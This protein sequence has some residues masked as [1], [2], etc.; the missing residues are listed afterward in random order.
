MKGSLIT[1][2][3]LL[4]QGQHGKESFFYTNIIMLSASGFR[5]LEN[6]LYSPQPSPPLP[7]VF[8]CFKDFD[9]YS[10]NRPFSKKEKSRLSQITLQILE[11]YLHLQ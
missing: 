7:N 11:V 6:C 3:A 8:Q 1:K 5:L 4:F 2:A 10:L 9:R